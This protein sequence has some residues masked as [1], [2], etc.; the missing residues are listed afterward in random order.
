MG[1]AQ[2]SKKNRLLC[3]YLSFSVPKID[4]KYSAM[5]VHS[6]TQDSWRALLQSA[7]FSR[8]NSFSSATPSRCLWMGLPTQRERIRPVS[9]VKVTLCCTPPSRRLFGRPKTTWYQTGKDFQIAPLPLKQW[10]SPNFVSFLSS[11]TAGIMKYE[12]V[13]KS[14][15]KQSWLIWA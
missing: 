15:C 12:A 5:L 10:H 2:K 13:R 1:K 14:C 8:P 4:A 3:P 11:R 7:L 6:F 9:L